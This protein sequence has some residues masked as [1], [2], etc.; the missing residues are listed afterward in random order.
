M[1]C[2]Y[3]SNGRQRGQMRGEGAHERLD[4]FRRHERDLDPP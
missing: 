3:Q 4:A 2:V 1:I